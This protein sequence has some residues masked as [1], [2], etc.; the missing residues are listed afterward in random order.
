MYQEPRI[1]DILKNKK[2]LLIDL[3]D[4]LYHYTKAHES[5]VLES[6]KKLKTHNSFSHTAPELS[7][8][9]QMYNDA[10]KI[11]LE[12]IFDQGSCRSKLLAFQIVVENFGK[13]TD[14]QLVADLNKTYWNAFYQNMHPKKEGLFFIEWAFSNQYPICI[15]TDMMLE[16]QIEKLK[17]LNLLNKVN[18]I[19][20][21]EE[22]GCEKPS[23]PLFEKALEKIQCSASEVVMVGDSKKKDGGC[24]ALSIEYIQV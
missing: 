4:T 6:F 9:T 7:E 8:F 23:L 3:D 12:R 11:I 24:E 17:V 5:G 18:F 13:K 14:Y 10:R 20:S 21:S 19:V 1:M 22:M 15:V 16:N 2:G